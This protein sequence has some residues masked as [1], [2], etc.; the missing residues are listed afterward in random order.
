M[1]S[2]GRRLALLAATA[3][4]LAVVAVAAW[5]VRPFDGGPAD[6]DAA[7]SVLYFDHIVAGHRLEA[8][9]NTTPKPVL[10]LVY[11]LLHALSGGWVVGAW[12]TIVVLAIGIVL[13]AEAA[14][15]TAGIEAGAFALVALTGSAVMIHGASAAGGLPWAFAGWM[16]AALALMRPAPRYG[17]AG[18]FLFLAALARQETFLF[19]GFATMALALAWIRFRWFR[20][21]RPDPSAWLLLVG[22]LA[23]GVYAIHDLLLTGD[24]LWWTKVAGISAEGRKVR[25]I[26][27]VARF[28]AT[29]LVGLWRLLAFGVVGALV[30][31]WRRQWLQFWSL[32]VMGPGVALFTLVLAWRHLTVLGHYLDPVTL[33]VTL[34]A[35]IGVGAILAAV[36]GWLTVRLAVSVRGIVPFVTVVVAGVAAVLLSSSWVPLSAATRSSA[37]SQAFAASRVEAILPTLR[38]AMPPIPAASSSDPGPEARPAPADI[39]VILPRYQANRIAVDLDIPPSRFRWIG[40]AGV[41]LASDPPRPGSLLY[42]DGR[43]HPAS[44]TDGTA[45]YRVSSPTVVGNVRVVPVYV[46]PSRQIWVERVEPAT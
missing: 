13:A 38:A 43:L 10:T 34:S 6:T 15:R 7:A 35:A 32:A 30:L 40:T 2:G 39:R 33:A 24:P 22:W 11:G 25:S 12:A 5:L 19:L 4:T 14:R 27:G 18:G 45:P 16:A 9:V 17:L 29:H 31:V 41:D 20:G 1:Q 28:N 21:A 37:G 26:G 46:D 23:I 36:R 8:F 44:V 3:L 42:F